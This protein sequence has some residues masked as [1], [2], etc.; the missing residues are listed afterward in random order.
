MEARGKG[1]QVPWGCLS[2]TCPSREPRSLPHHPRHRAEGAGWGDPLGARWGAPVHPSAPPRPLGGG[3]V[4]AILT[5]CSAR[6]ARLSARHKTG[7]IAEVL[8]GSTLQHSTTLT[9]PPL[10]SRPAA[11]SGTGGI[12][13]A[14]G[15][16]LTHSSAHLNPP[17][18][19]HNALQ[20]NTLSYGD[21]LILSPGTEG[22]AVAPPRPPS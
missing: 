6:R 21:S 17:Q 20:S 2:P 18:V 9:A 14:L 7:L 19:D 4:G 13:D 10:N 11:L 8:I 15:G 16:Q 22:S 12:L 1:T 3:H 5:V